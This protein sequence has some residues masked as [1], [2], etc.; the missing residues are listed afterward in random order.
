M[1][2]I[3]IFYKNFRFIL[4]A[5]RRAR[6]AIFIAFSLIFLYPLQGMSIMTNYVTEIFASTNPN[7]SPLYAS[8]LITT[9]VIIANLVFLNVVDRAG[10]RKFYIFSSL[11][12]SAG[13]TLF[14]F[15]LYF[16]TG[17]RAFDCMPVVCL[18]YVLFANCLGMYPIPWLI[19]IEIM[20]KKV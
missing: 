8:T 1:H 4:S 19:V 20:P 16:L 13:L 17:N 3:S 11:A 2:E 15:Y 6:K 18:S 5:N 10:R 12:T 7:I 9:I 14:A